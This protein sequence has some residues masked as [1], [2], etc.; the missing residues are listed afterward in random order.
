[1]SGGDKGPRAKRIEKRWLTIGT[2]ICIGIGLFLGYV[3]E[4]YLIAI[5]VGIIIAFIVQ[6]LVGSSEE[7]VKNSNDDGSA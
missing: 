5:T 3:T 7:Y 6:R 1:L 4:N 2:I